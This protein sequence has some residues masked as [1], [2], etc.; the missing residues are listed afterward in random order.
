MSSEK[1]QNET[2][3]K[4][5]W[6]RVIKPG[7][8]ALLITVLVWSIYKAR[9]EPPPPVLR[10]PDAAAHVAKASDAGTDAPNEASVGQ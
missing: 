8:Y 2:P 6:S 4:E 10:R 1:D 7:F 9:T 3:A 5:G